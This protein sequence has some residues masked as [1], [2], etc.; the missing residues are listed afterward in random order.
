MTP[1]P[2]NKKYSNIIVLDSSLDIYPLLPLFDGLISDYSSIMRDFGLLNRP[3]VLYTFDLEQYISQSRPVFKR[4]WDVYERLTILHN[5]EELKNF[6]LMK[7]LPDSYFPVADYYDCPQDMDA[8]KR[9]IN[10][11]S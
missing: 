8:T 4:F 6:I 9:L 3:V 10:R 2:R 11:L 7:E 5:Y 1:T